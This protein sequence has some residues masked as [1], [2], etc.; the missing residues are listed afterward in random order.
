MPLIRLLA[1]PST[2][3]NPW[4][5]F[6]DSWFGIANSI[7]DAGAPHIDM[8]NHNV[9][10]VLLCSFLNS[11]R[12]ISFYDL[13]RALCSSSHAATYSNS[14]SSVSSEPT[15]VYIHLGLHFFTCM[16]LHLPTMTLMCYFF[17]QSLSIAGL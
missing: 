15:I 16:I 3:P 2:F 1:C 8:R 17:P 6:S 13:Y 4:Y 14:S 5:A 9:F 7:Q 11:E 12:S 10:C